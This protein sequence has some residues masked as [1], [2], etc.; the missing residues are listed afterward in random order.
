MHE[1]DDALAYNF[2][3]S[4]PGLEL[5]RFDEDGGR[6]GWHMTVD[7]VLKVM[8]TFRRAGTIVS[9]EQAQT[10]LD[11]KFAIDFAT[12]TLL[13]TL[14]AKNGGMATERRTGR[15]VGAVLPPG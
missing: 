8:G 9:P 1:P 12:F 13:G 6:V 15:A 7:D 11:S 4:G 3:V 2:P 10:M 14:Y 5:G